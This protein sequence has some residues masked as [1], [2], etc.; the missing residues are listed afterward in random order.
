MNKL[1][2]GAILIALSLISFGVMAADD[3]PAQILI[4]NV[5]IFDGKSESLSATS[6]VLIEGNI[7]KQIST[8]SIS[9]PGATIIAGDGRTLMPGLIDNHVHLSLTGATLADIEN[10]MT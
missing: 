9:S 1:R 4:T 6:N 8:E 3:A 7:I 10:N 2:N 5:N